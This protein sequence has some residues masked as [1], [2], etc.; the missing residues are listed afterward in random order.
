MVTAQKITKKFG[1]IIALSDLSFKIEPGEFI[2]LTGPSGSGKSTLLKL[3]LR[4]YKPD[5]GELLVDGQ[6]VGKLPAKKLHVYRRSI[7]VVFQDFRLLMDRN[8]W[9]NV[10]LPLQVKNTKPAEISSAVKSA[11]DL[12]GLSD[13]TDLFPPQLSGGELQRV[14]LARAIVAKPKLLLADEPTGNLDPQNAKSILRLLKD[15]HTELK[16]TIIMATHNA[17]LVNQANLRV[18]SLNSGKLSKDESKGKYE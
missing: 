1:S 5:S 10:A 11:L 15:I 8:V 6:S 17:D 16:T 9:E 7:G 18:I 3:I 4:E 13:R 12:V 2:F 14:A